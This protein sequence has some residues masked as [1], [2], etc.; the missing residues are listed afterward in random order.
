MPAITDLPLPYVDRLPERLVESVTLVVIHCTEL[1]DLATA[2]EYGEKV[3]Y[4]SGAGNSGHYYIDRDGTIQRYVPGTR[5]AHHVRGRNADS[6]RSEERR[7]GKE[8]RARWARC[9][10]ANE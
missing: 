4:E 2:R 6:I 1:P 5:I 9:D 3:L 10:I 7:V 8:C